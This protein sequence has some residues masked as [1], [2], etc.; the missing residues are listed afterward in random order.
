MYIRHDQ[1]PL[2]KCNLDVLFFVQV[3]QILCCLAW[4]PEWAEDIVTLAHERRN[5][6]PCAVVG[7]DIAAGEEHFDQVGITNVWKRAFAYI[8]R[9]KY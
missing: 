8:K 3:N 1:Y 6:F 9:S 7:I 4:R 5:N 2:M